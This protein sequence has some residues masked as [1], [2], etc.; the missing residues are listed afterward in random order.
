MC[1]TDFLAIFLQDLGFRDVFE[2]FSFDFSFG[3]G[4]RYYQPFQG[5][6]YFS[7]K[8]VDYSY[9]YANWRG[10]SDSAVLLITSDFESVA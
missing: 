5:L 7:P 9:F 8:T 2:E 10:E 3:I 1:G 6:C 4:G